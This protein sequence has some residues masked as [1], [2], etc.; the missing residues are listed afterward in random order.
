[1]CSSDPVRIRLRSVT[2]TNYCVPRTRMKFG[3]RAF[4][5]AGPVVW[6]SIHAAVREANTVSSLKRKL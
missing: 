1:V 4:S 6:N 3:D 5:V 2:S